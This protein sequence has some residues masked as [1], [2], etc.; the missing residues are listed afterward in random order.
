[1]RFQFDDLP[2]AQR[3]LRILTLCSSDEG[4]PINCENGP[5]SEDVDIKWLLRKSYIEL[6]RTKPGSRS[7]VTK[8]FATPSGLAAQVGG[9]LP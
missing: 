6:R 2:A 8:A 9:T 1:M 4:L 5:S 7:R 3:R